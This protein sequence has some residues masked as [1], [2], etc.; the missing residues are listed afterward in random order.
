LLLVRGKGRVGG[1]ATD[2]ADGA[3]E[4]D[5]SGSMPASVAARQISAEMA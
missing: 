2:D 4:L 3:Q 5:R 1:P